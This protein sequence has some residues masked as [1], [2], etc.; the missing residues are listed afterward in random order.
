M[1]DNASA[2]GNRPNATSKT[3]PATAQIA[4]GRRNGRAM[5]PAVAT[6]AML[7][8]ATA[9]PSTAM[10]TARAPDLP[11]QPLPTSLTRLL[12]HHQHRAGGVAH[13]MAGIGAEEIGAYAG[14]VR[15]HDDEVGTHPLGFIEDFAVDIALQHGSRH[16][17]RRQSGFPGD[18]GDRLLGRYALLRL[19]VGRPV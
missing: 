3:A 11:T 12:P 16:L 1:P 7:Q 9:L 2:H 10:G 18:D 17:V 8:A 5:T 6:A 13:H 15:A 14:A 4:S 19:E